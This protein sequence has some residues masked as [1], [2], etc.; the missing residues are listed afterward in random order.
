MHESG[1]TRVKV[2]TRG[3]EKASDWSTVISLYYYLIPRKCERLFSSTLFSVNSRTDCR[4]D[5]NAYFESLSR[6]SNGDEIATEMRKA[7]AVCTRSKSMIWTVLKALCSYMTS[8]IS[9]FLVE[10]YHN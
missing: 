2:P 10:V 9:N 3:K 6:L 7:I 1:V 5:F 4:M 8:C